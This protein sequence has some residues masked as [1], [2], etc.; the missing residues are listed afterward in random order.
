M[1]NKIIIFLLVLLQFNSLKAEK[2]QSLNPNINIDDEGAIYYLLSRCSGLYIQVAGLIEKQEPDLSKSYQQIAEDI[3]TTL[4]VI[5]MGLNDYSGEEAISS[6]NNLISKIIEIYGE[7][8]DSNYVNTGSYF[9]EIT[10][11]DLVTCQ[12]FLERNF[13]F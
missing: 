12:E 4:Y 6:V 5:D 7:D 11:D 2:L 9:S 8:M 10:R 1:K 13:N 3:T